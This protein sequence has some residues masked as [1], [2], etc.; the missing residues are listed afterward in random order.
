MAE[1]MLRRSGPDG[2]S[3]WRVPLT[4]RLLPA[5]RAEN[6]ARKRLLLREISAHVGSQLAGC[7]VAMWSL[8]FKPETSYVRE[9]PGCML[10]GAGAH[11]RA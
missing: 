3:F 4:P 9:A 8:A 10:L 11:V 6:D 1:P 5:M 7:T 2:C